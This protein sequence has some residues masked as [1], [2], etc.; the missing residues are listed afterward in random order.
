MAKLSEF[1]PIIAPASLR[2]E[3]LLK[4]LGATHV[5]DRNLAPEA[6][7]AEISKI[8]SGTPIEYVYD[9]IS[10]ADTQ[11]VAY[12]ALAPGGSLLLVLPD[13][14]PAELKAVGDGKKVI[15][16]FGNVQPPQNRKIGVEMYK[17]LTGW[18]ETGALVVRI[19]FCVL[20]EKLGALADFIH[21]AE[22]RR[23]ASQW[24]GRNSR[25]VEENGGE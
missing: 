10:L 12:Q 9:S 13:Q 20:F 1:S 5:L 2:N 24:S 17:R 21:A 7:L 16:V 11:P 25:W 18:L 22:Q 14:I 4:S 6:I 15:N 3:A 19:W 8:T 23:G